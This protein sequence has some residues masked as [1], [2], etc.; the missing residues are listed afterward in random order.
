MDV[1][2]SLLGCIALV[3]MNVLPRLLYPIQIFPVLFSKRG[4]EGHK[5]MAQLFYLEQA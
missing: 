5:W 1:T 3:K 4:I 2:V